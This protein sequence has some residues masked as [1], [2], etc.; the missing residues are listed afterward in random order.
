MIQVESLTRSYGD[1]TA[2]DQ[3]SFDIAQGEIVG[4]LGHNGAGKTTIMKMMT[5]FLEPTSGIIKIDGL[6]ILEQLQEV[7]QK[8]GYLPENCPVYPEMSVVDYLD[9]AA[10]LHGLEQHE[11]GE[12][13]RDVLAKTEL[14]DRAFHMIST[15]SRGLRQ[16]VGVAQ[17][18]LHEPKILI[19]DE[20]TNG[21]DPTQI[22]HM[23][24]LIRSLAEHATIILS[25]HILQ[26]VQAVCDRVI[27]VRDGSKVMDAT[28]QELRS[29]NRLLIGLNADL[30]KTR[31]ILSS[32]SEIEQV[33]LMEHSGE[34]Y[35][36]ALSL[37]GHDYLTL[38]PRVAKAIHDDGCNLY[39][40][41]EENRDL[42]TIFRELSTDNIAGGV[43]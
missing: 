7:Q 5:G 17:A 40:L 12:R 19:L 3:V 26:E 42:E 25:T 15:L 27:I 28:L 1:F 16:R 33:D 34:N 6:D 35:Q 37:N 2:V 43:I 14:T 39:T 41:T 10:S 23:R 8:I 36:Y 31:N 24:E 11:R 18:L 32:I 13:I 21:L 20:P 9:Y 4:L 29:D 30:D 22:Q 38:A